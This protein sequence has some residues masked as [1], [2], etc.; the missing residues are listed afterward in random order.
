MAVVTVVGVLRWPWKIKAH[1]IMATAV[2][3]TATR[4]RRCECGRSTGS[5]AGIAGI[6]VSA[7]DRF[8]SALIGIQPFGSRN[9]GAMNCNLIGLRELRPKCR[10]MWKSADLWCNACGDS[11]LPPS[12]QT[13]DQLNEFPIDYW[14]FDWS[15]FIH[16]GCREQQLKHL[17]FMNHLPADRALDWILDSRAV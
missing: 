13:D 14:I 4:V 15:C 6:A 9:A 10:L 12:T 7:A 11:L 3:I 16:W 17:N 2:I 8:A 5:S 1:Q